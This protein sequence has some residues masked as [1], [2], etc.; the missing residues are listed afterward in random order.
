MI[1]ITIN[2]REQTL[3]VPPD[4]PLLWVL[5]DVLDM[6]GTKFGCGANLC[7]ACTVHKDGQAV[8]SCQ[9]AIG[10]AA[11]SH[12]TTI[13]GLDPQGAHPV[14]LAWIKEQVPACGY[15]QSGQIMNAAAFLAQNPDPEDE[16]IVRAMEGNLC[17][18]SQY[19]RIQ[20]A[21]K[22]AAE[23]MKAKGATTN[24]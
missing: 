5:R 2:G 15:C 1:N 4:M 3:D 7:G 14:Q 13:E 18:C 9:V 8:R 11:G 12:I 21:V 22:T 23:D 19:V 24:G 20:R 16:E 6:T 17:R 10:D